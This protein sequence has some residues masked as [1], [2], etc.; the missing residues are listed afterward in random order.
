MRRELIAFI[1]VLTVCTTTYCSDL[2]GDFE[3]DLDGWESHDAAI[4]PDRLGFSTT[5]ATLHD[6]SLRLDSPGGFRWAIRCPLQADPN[7]IVA[8]NHV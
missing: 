2:V 3:G 5:G 1:L 7:I 4:T 6:F 8:N